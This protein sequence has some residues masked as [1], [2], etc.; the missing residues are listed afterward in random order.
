M[1][2]KIF[3]ILLFVTFIILLWILINRKGS[4]N[5]IRTKILP[6]FFLGSFIFLF[7][8]FITTCIALFTVRN[9][10]PEEITDKSRTVY[11]KK[12]E[13]GFQLIRNGKPFYI[14]GAAGDAHFDE[15]AGLGGN[16]IRLY[17]TINLQRNLDEALKYGL[18]VIV[19]IPIP[20]Y[21]WISYRNEEESRILK[22]RVKFF[23]KKYRNHRALLM[24]NLGNEI[25]Y[26]KVH[27]KDF[28][29]IDKSKI[30]FI[31][32]FNELIDFIHQEDKNHPVST[33][34]D[35][36]GI[37]QYAKLRMF[38]PGLD[39][40]AFNN[41]G[42]INNIFETINK[43]SDY[44]GA[45]PIYISEFGSDGWWD[46]ESKYTP[47]RSPIEQTS[48]KKAEQVRVRYDIIKKNSNYC[49]GSLIF[50]WGNKYECTDT[51]F[52]LF[53]DEYKSEILMETER[54]WKNLNNQPKL[55]G[56]EYMLVNGKGAFDHLIFTPDE[57]IKTELKIDAIGNDSILIKWEIYPDDWQNGWFIKEY[58]KKILKKP[59]P[60]ECF[61]S[62]EMNQA[63]FIT[64]D[65][66]GPYRIF[67]YIFDRNGYFAS[68]NTPFYVL[69]RK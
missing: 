14:Q 12:S 62:T 56:L 39:L 30:N 52:S 2:T 10:Y 22:Q 58:N 31:K 35:K 29:R 69:N 20:M 38:S 57:L 53:K 55:I 17:D 67:A 33:S 51:W 23:V 32:T 63:S 66:E 50:F 26:P 21:S 36:I 3:F 8:L 18:A 49:L 15:L 59:S 60:V 48:T 27:W 65:K 43:T 37:K 11:I 6:I 64:P 45:F 4:L 13:E 40:L 46:N 1:K 54:L 34:I 16:T 24:W 61:V 28:L 44:I 7:G 47:W 41:F 19:D 68:T 9:S 25:N 5:L 42:D